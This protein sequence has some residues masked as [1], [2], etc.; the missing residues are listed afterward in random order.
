MIQNGDLLA[1]VASL[2]ETRFGSVFCGTA[3]G[4]I[5]LRLGDTLNCANSF[6]SVAVLPAMGSLRSR[7]RDSAASARATSMRFSAP[8]GK[9]IGQPLGVGLAMQEADQRLGPLADLLSFIGKQRWHFLMLPDVSGLS[10]LKGQQN[11]KCLTPGR[12]CPEC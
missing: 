2:R 9:K 1:C 4:G 10:F 11:V 3:V 8:R 5:R 6:F 12:T 7:M